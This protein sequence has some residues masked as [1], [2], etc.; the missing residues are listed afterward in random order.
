MPYCSQCGVEVGAD[1]D[2]CPLC[3]VPI[4]KFGDSGAAGERPY[5]ERYRDA[6]MT[7]G[8][9]RLISWLAFTALFVTA[10]LVVLTVNL[11]LDGRI[12]WGRY[13]LA[14]IGAGWIY[15]GVLLLFIRRLWLV[16]LLNFAVTTGFLALVDVFDGSL[17]W[18]LALGLPISGMATAATLLLALFARVFKKWP[19]LLTST[20]LFTAGVFCLGL[21][22]LV[23]GYRGQVRISWS[24]IVMVSIYPIAVLLFFYH[25]FLR[26]RVDLKRYF[27]V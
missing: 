24:F 3:N 11:V 16:I 22:L 12:T 20:A 4:Q 18:F 19:A 10:F 25:F 17:D 6:P 23:S 27:H 1:V 13:A 26:K 21:D 8:Q 15:T 7:G 9:K 14:G 5:P 2:S